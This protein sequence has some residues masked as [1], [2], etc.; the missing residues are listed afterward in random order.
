MLKRQECVGL[1]GIFLINRIILGPEKNKVTSYQGVYRENKRHHDPNSDKVPRHVQ[2][3]QF[4][5][6]E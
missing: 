5:I 4:G 6:C 1:G 3:S 2:H